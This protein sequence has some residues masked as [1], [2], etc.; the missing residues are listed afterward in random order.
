MTNYHN[1][2]MNPALKACMQHRKNKTGVATQIIIADDKMHIGR[3][4]D[5]TPIA[6]LA[7]AMHKEGMH[8]SSDMRHAA[9]LPLVIVEKYCNENGITFSEFMS[10]QTHIRRMCNDPDNKMFRIWHG[11]V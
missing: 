10:N 2:N 5:C 8:G 6:E 1:K 4:Q 11:V 3:S 7:H 9:K